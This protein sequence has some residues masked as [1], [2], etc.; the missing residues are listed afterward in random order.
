M[1]SL[2][3]WKF[4][5]SI[6]MMRCFLLLQMKAMSRKIKTCAFIILACIENADFVQFEYTTPDGMEKTYKLTIDEANDYL[7]VVSKGENIKDFANS[8]WELKTLIDI[9]G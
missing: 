2:T 1:K 8:H 3:A 5:I 4:T 7:G 6:H 9:Y